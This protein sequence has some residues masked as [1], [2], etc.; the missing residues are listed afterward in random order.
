MA[1]ANKKNY[2]LYQIDAGSSFRSLA[3]HSLGRVGKSTVALRYA[4]NKLQRDE[5][6]ALFWVYTEKLVSIRQSFTDVALRL[7]LPDA[8]P[9][10]QDENCAVVLNWLQHTQCRWLIVYD[11]AEDPD[12][13][14]HYWPLANR[15]Q[16]LITRNPAF[17]FEL[18]DGGM[19]I[20]NW[21]NDTGLRFL[22]YLLSTDIST[23]L[24]ED[25]VT[26]A[27]QLSEVLRGHALAIST[28][29]GLMHRRALSITEFMKFYNQHRS[30]VLGI[31][32]NRSINALWEISFKSLDPQTHAILGV[33][34]FIE[35]DSIPQTLF[36][37][38]SPASL[39]ASLSFCSDPFRTFMTPEQR[40][41]AFNDA[42]ILVSKA[43]P[44]RDSNV[45]QLYLMWD[46]CAMYLQ[47]L[48]SLKDC[49]REEKESNPNFAALQTYCDLNNAYQRYLLELNSYEELAD[50]IEINTMALST[51]PEQQQTIGLQGS[52]TSHRGPVAHPPRFGEMLVRVEV[53]DR[54]PLIRSDHAKRDTET[55]EGREASRP[56][57]GKMRMAG[58]VPSAHR[59]R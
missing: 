13:I 35:P 39:P 12:L 56:R 33:M 44:R 19:D 4:E 57:T 48:I 41:Q 34:S 5:L 30:E 8:R 6:D 38:D 7:K 27:H 40:Q 47:Y 46:R 20:T 14:R 52:L 37:T 42:T 16:A 53:K 10:D 23:D 21:D 29:A 26:S 49:F 11:N 54:I 45:V 2:S 1:L 32:G 22:L 51:L 55:G 31:S 18:A 24:E 36:E 3:L 25:E 59:S 43:F 17:S 50:L 15:C 9:G 28:T 58:Q